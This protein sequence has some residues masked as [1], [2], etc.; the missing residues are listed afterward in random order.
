MLFEKGA[1][2]APKCLQIKPGKWTK[3]SDNR[4]NVRLSN[5]LLSS[6]SPLRTRTKCGR[7]GATIRLAPDGSKSDPDVQTDPPLSGASR[8]VA[9]P[10][11]HLTASGL[12]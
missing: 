8:I 9:P 2:R 3:Q 7:G 12:R 5:R 4:L 11:P 10:L 1:E 6:Y